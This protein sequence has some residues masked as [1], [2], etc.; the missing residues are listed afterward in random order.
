MIRN[1]IKV[2]ILRIKIYIGQIIFLFLLN[3]L[4]LLIIT[5]LKHLVVVVVDYIKKIIVL[6]K[7]PLAMVVNKKVISK[8]VFSD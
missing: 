8:S 4:N 3:L 7:T 1:I 2:F 6:L 5:L